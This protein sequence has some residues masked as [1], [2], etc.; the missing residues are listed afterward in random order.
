MV[1]RVSIVLVCWITKDTTENAFPECPV[2]TVVEE[3]ENTETGIYLNTCTCTSTSTCTISN[4]SV[5][6]SKFLDPE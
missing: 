4:I 3:D 2:S 6:V 1:F 5:D